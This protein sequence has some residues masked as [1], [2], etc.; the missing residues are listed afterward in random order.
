MPGVFIVD[1]ESK[2]FQIQKYNIL[3]FVY[4]FL[5]SFQLKSLNGQIF[6][7]TKYILI[8]VTF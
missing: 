3:L 6:L 5:T 2:I 1:N 8:F 7:K 4:M